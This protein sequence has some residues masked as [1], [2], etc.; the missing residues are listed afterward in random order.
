MS[1]TTTPVLSALLG[2]TFPISL[3]AAGPPGRLGTLA[4][5]DRVFSM[6]WWN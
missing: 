5:L 1:L 2:N 4:T 6:I 3:S